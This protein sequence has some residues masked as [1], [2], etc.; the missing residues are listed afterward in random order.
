MAAERPVNFL[1]G[2]PLNRLSWMRDS[3]I[4]LDTLAASSKARWVVF[5][6]G[7]PL[8]A[9][10]S[11]KNTLVKFSTADV[12]PF[13]GEAPLFGQGQ[14]Q[15]ERS[16]EKVSVLESARFFGA[17]VVFL[18]VQE[19]G[20]NDFGK[21]ED[22]EAAANALNGDPYFS[23]DLSDEEQS[24]VDALVEKAQAAHEDA[25]VAFAEPRSAI[26]GMSSE[27]AAAFAVGRSMLDWNSRNRFCSACGQ[28]THSLWGGWKLACSSLVPWANNGDRKPCP[29]S[30]G[31]HNVNHPRT[32]AAIIVA[33][34]SDANDKILLGH[35]KKFPGNF[36]STLA[37]F[38]E[39][40]ESFEDCVKREILEE[41]GV[42][43]YNVRYH[44]AQPW[45]YPSSIMVGFVA[46]ADVNEPI[47]T[48][49]DNELADARWYTREQV[50]SVLNHA[51]GTNISRREYKRIDDNI[52]GQSNVVNKNGPPPTE[53]AGAQ[54]ASTQEA[55]AASAGPDPEKAD[56]PLFR[57]PPLTTIAGVLISDWAHG[58]FPASPNAN[59]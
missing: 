18:G 16:V 56:E 41:A 20:P 38:L 53:G 59:L 7:S 11:S 9:Y 15:G 24:A 54:A 19:S 14:V 25:K 45:P 6:A 42:H 37:G 35:N 10:R 4:Y 27:D 49:L 36:Y 48:D 57:V 1:S 34:T 31:L 3:A 58:R 43:V 44:S 28:P 2:S 52:N 29:T 40:G 5:Q 22:A 47:R 51:D 26:R 21:I 55:S 8:T 39:P 46:T 12:R 30:K 33:I 32:D 17:R 13:I 23:V 50:L